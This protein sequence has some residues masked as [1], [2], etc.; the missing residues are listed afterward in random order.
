MKPARRS[1]RF[2]A[3]FFLLP[4]SPQSLTTSRPASLFLLSC[5]SPLSTLH[6]SPP[7]GYTV[8]HLILETQT[9]QGPFPCRTGGYH[10]QDDISHPRGTLGRQVQFFIVSVSH[11]FDYDFDAILQCT[12][13]LY[14]AMEYYPDFAASRLLR[15]TSVEPWI[16][17]TVLAFLHLHLGL[18][19]P[20]G[21][22]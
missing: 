11:A 3:T 15:H 1:P 13:L 22:A 9:F 17:L 10:Y 5:H 16:V 14:Y 18:A 8:L 19:W 20:E 6:N 2:H 21:K 12:V 7:V 4:N